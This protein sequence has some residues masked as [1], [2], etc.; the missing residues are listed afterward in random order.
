MEFEVKACDSGK[1]LDRFLAM[2][3]LELSRSRI[4]RLIQ[5]GHVEISGRTRPTASLKVRPGDRIRVHIPPPLPLEIKPRSL[6]LDIVFEDQYL[7]VLNKQ[8]GLVV[9]PGAGH[10]DSTLVHGLLYHCK[11]LSGIGGVLRPG[12]V[13]RLDKDTSGLMLVAKTDAVHRLLVDRFKH[14]EIKKLYAALISGVP[15]DIE[16]LIEMPIGRHPV[17]R[18]RMAVNI[19]TG[20]AAATRWRKIRSWRNVALVNVRIFTGR[21]HQIRVHMKHIG[22]PVLGDELYGGPRKLET[23][24]GTIPIRRQMLHSTQLNLTHPVTGNDMEFKI[25]LPSDMI[26]LIE[27]LDTYD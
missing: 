9:H 1:R 26:E 13:H 22:H 14:G 10:E 2:C 3:C 15:S 5:T 19:R 24:T 7:I 17:Y 21:T 16:G 4:K 20:K 11:D 8:P 25:P 23:R 12:I 27:G 6:P 18:K